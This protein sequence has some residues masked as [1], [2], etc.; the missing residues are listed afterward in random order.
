MIFF[1]SLFFIIFSASAL[2][3]TSQNKEICILDLTSKNNEPTSGNVFSIEHI[4]KTAGFSYTV[5]SSMNEAIKSH[6]IIPSSNIETTTFVQAE[7]DSLKNFI[8]RGGVAVV[9][10]LKDPLLFPFF[11]ISSTSF[12]TNRF[13]LKFKT[14]YNDTIFK[15]FD[16]VNEKKISLGDASDYTLT[17]G[18]RSYSMT[19]G[20]TLATYETSEIAACH[21]R[22]ISGH[23][24][25]VGTQYKDVILRPQVK[26]D[27]KAS[28]AYSNSFEPGQ[29]VFIFL[30][31]GIIKRHSPNVIWKHTAPCKFKSAM[32]ITHDV[33][34]TS[35]ID[36]FDNYANYEKI[37][38]I[39]STYL[40]TTH[41]MHDKVAKDFLEGNEDDIQ[42]VSEM[43]HDIQSHSVSHVPDF[44]I[45]SII[46]VGSP[47]N[48][49]NNYQPYY[50]GVRSSN[51][52]VFGE[53]EVSR[54]LLKGITKKEVTC[55][56]PGYLAFHNNLINVLDSLHYSFST[57]HSANDVMTNFPFFSHTDLSMNGRLTKVLEIPNH[58][59]DIFASDPIS[60]ENFLQKV[61]IWKTNF[62]RAYRNNASSVLL[63]HPTRYYKLFA[64]QMLIQ[65]L[66]EN[67]IITNITEFGN[68]WLNRNEVDMNTVISGDTVF[69][70][71][72]KPVSQIN[73]FVSFIIN[74]GRKFYTVKVYDANMTLV[75][76]SISNWDEN[77]L[78]LHNDCVRPDYSKYLINE[79]PETSN[80][81]IYPNPSDKTNGRFHF[82]L[83]NEL[84][85]NINVYDLKGKLVCIPVKNKTFNLGVYDLELSTC[86]LAA[87]TYIVKAKIGEKSYSLKWVLE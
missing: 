37:N 28:R 64:Q 58:I 84:D 40:I 80:L 9:T 67:A 75:N 66:P 86:G 74:N 16:D 2:F 71:L 46:P 70:Y 33:D 59:S 81:Y 12:S 52:T 10:N 53:A 49:K 55:F 24:Y 8:A 79:S 13:E 62:F 14:D 72:N 11:G 19:I 17:I 45:E 23:T 50:D 82:E 15:M 21:S 25:L 5:S 73:K 27:Y 48:N 18:T 63:I 29:D 1:R 20:D 76:Y 39:F 4:L 22:Y 31:S 7:R 77:D 54:D 69:V 32:V 43:G 44:D 56:R 65:A 3:L 36:M 85:I 57:S 61:D 35:S 26:Q 6:F 51:V 34:A 78:I 87:G 42:R 83:M 38:T 60:E 68:Y 41:Y 47:G 30:I